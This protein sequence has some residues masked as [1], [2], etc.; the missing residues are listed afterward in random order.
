MTLVLT[1]LEGTEGFVVYYDASVVGLGCV[2][3]QHKKVIAY[4]S[5][6]LKV[7]ERKYPSH[8]LKLLDMVFA[9]KIYRH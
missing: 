2:F 8:D 5:R 6:K 4:A 1:L 7:H 3:M 9:L